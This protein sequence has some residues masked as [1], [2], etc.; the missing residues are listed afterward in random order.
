[1][2]AKQFHNK[3]ASLLSS[4]RIRD[5]KMRGRG[6]CTLHGCWVRGNFFERGGKCIGITREE[7]PRGVGEKFALARYRELDELCCDRGDD[8]SCDSGDCHD[9]IFVLAT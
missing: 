4:E 7:C 1:M 6:R 3:C 9:G 2:R 8:D 5:K